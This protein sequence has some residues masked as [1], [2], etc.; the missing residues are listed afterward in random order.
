MGRG[1]SGLILKAMR[2]DDYVFTVI[3]T[4]H[5][6]DHYHRIRFDGGAFLTENPWFP[7]MWVRLWIPKSGEAS[8]DAD[9]GSLAQR[10]YTIVD[11]EGSEFS[12]E[13]AVHDGPA[14]RWAVDAEPGDRIAATMMGSDLTVP[15]SPAPSEY[16]LVGDTASI[17]AINSLVDSAGVPCR[18]FLEYQHIAE[19]EIP[20]RGASV[21]WVPRED[22]GATLVSTVTTASIPRDAFLFVAAE[23]RATR[24]ITR[25]AK[26]DLGLPKDRIKSQ[27]YWLQRG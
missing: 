22:R 12:I 1:V 19:R 16:V 2:A 7:T 13:F 10:G 15:E 24:E 26:R 5:V 3:R 18:V 25:A 11:P 23:S 9:E 14:P 17:P 8:T 27:A 4:E 6:N 21:T 20:V